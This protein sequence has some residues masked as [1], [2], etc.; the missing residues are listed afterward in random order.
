[1]VTDS[2]SSLILHDLCDCKEQQI[3]A[4]SHYPKK[5]PKKKTV[6]FLDDPVIFV[7]IDD[8]SDFAIPLPTDS[9]TDKG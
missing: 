3:I 2:P 9:V 1:V 6:T 5:T 4:F 8:T 7:D